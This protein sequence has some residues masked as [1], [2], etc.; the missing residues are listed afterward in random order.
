MRP[1]GVDWWHCSSAELVREAELVHGDHDDASEA[2]F[3][4][5]EGSWSVRL[6]DPM[7]VNAFDSAADAS[8]WLSAE[9]SM[10][11]ADGLGG[12]LAYREMLELGICD[13]VVVSTDGE[14][15]TLWDGF[16]RTAIAIIRGEPLL[17]IVGSRDP[18]SS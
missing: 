17:A 11:E 10:L 15:Y 12:H 9:I 18:G 16:H 4:P 2:F 13:P 6:I 8:E 7:A 14:V 3:Q 5:E 1:S